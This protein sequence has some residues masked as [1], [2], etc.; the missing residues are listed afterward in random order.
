MVRGI[1]AAGVEAGA[2]VACEPG[3]ERQAGGPMGNKFSLLHLRH[4]AGVW[5]ASHETV[6][7][8]AHVDDLQIGDHAG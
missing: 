4:V 8:S 7:S 6:R 5:L 1:G 2:A 3:L